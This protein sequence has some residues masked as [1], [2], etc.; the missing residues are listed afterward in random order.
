MYTRYQGEDI[1]VAWKN[2]SSKPVFAANNL[3]WEVIAPD[4]V[5]VNVDLSATNIFTFKEASSSSSP[6]DDVATVSLTYM[7]DSKT[8]SAKERSIKVSNKPAMPQGEYQIINPIDTLTV[9]YLDKN[10]TAEISAKT[11]F[12][13]VAEDQYGDTYDQTPLFTVISSKGLFSI[14]STL[15]F[16]TTSGSFAIQAATNTKV[17]DVDTIKVYVTKDDFYEFKVK[18]ISSP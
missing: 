2:S 10:N 16:P 1:K 12:K 5:T 11:T 13:L 17:G 3:I 15:T 4:E 14:D 18:Y 9:N 8:L 7:S 6:I